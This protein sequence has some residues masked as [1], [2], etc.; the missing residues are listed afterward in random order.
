MTAA[1]ERRFLLNSDSLSDYCLLFHYSTSL[2]VNQSMMLTVVSLSEFLLQV[3]VFGFVFQLSIFF[4]LL[5]VSISAWDQL[6]NIADIDSKDTS[7]NNHI[8]AYIYC[9]MLEVFGL[10]SLEK[11]I[12]WTTWSARL[13]LCI[14]WP[15]LVINSTRLAMIF[16]F[17]YFCSFDISINQNIF[18]LICSVLLRLVVFSISFGELES[19]F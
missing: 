3:S 2:F 13:K 1:I 8:W 6:L 18:E 15:W 9:H 16:I 10:V 17:C 12:T 14:S 19:D 4:G 5:S 7:L 11:P